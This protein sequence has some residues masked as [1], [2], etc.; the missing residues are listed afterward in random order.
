MYSSKSVIC[1]S[2]FYAEIV[3]KFLIAVLRR[4]TSVHE[5]A[6][7]LTPAA[8]TSVVEHFQLVRDYEGNYPGR[9]AFLEHYKPADAAVAVLEGVYPLETH[10]EIEDILQRLRLPAGIFRKEPAHMPVYLLRRAGLHTSDFVRKSFVCSYREPVL[11]AV[12]C[13]GLQ[14]SVQLSDKSFCKRPSG[15]VDYV[16]DA[17]EMIDGLHNV[18][19]VESLVLSGTDGVGLEDIARLIA[20]QTAALDVVG[21]VCQVYLR[22][23]VYASSEGGVFFFAQASEQR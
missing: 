16:I 2:V 9:E 17:T 5:I 15:V 3:H 12:G 22:P 6:V 18:V 11:P 23:V 19:Y 10:M 14:D 21:V 1:P 4:Q 20:G 13:S 7:S 8:Q